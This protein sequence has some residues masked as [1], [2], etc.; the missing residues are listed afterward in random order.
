MGATRIVIPPALALFDE[1]GRG[2]KSATGFTLNSAPPQLADVMTPKSRAPRTNSS[3][4]LKISFWWPITAQSLTVIQRLSRIQSANY[5]PQ[6]TQIKEK[7]GG[8]APETW[9]LKLGT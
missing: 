9:T 7:Q 6:I 4:A 1:S 2:G 8:R 3:L 5:H